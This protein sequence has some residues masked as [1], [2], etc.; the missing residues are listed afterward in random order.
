VVMFAASP[1]VYAVMLHFL[2]GISYLKTVWFLMSISV[3]LLGILGI[4]AVIAGLA[5]S[6]GLMF[7][8]GPLSDEG[9]NEEICCAP[10]KHDKEGRLYCPECREYIDDE[11]GFYTVNRKE[12][13]ILK[14][15]K[16]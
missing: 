13:R 9:G 4:A 6:M 5:A 1:G 11:G 14:K 16:L 8:A 10:L 2:P 12:R 7:M 3:V 15:L